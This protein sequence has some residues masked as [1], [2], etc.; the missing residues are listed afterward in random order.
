MPC[1]AGR[2]MYNVRNL[3]DRIPGKALKR[4]CK[5]RELP[6][7]GSVEELRKAL[8]R[9][10]GR[11]V[12]NLLVDL[13]REDL[14]KLFR[15]AVPFEGVDYY[16]P[17][18]GQQ[19]K[20]ALQN[21][22]WQLFAHNQLPQALVPASQLDL[23][24]SSE[25]E[26]D[27]EDEPYEP[28][29]DNHFRRIHDAEGDEEDDPY[30]EGE[31]PPLGL[32]ERV[33]GIMDQQGAMG[34]PGHPLREGLTEGW[35]RPRSL[36]RLLQALD[37]AVPQRLRVSRFQEVI[38]HLEKLGIEAVQADDETLTPFTRDSPSPGIAS[39]VRLR[40]RRVEPPEE[41]PAERSPRAPAAK[42]PTPRPSVPMISPDYPTPPP[43]LVI[44]TT[45]PAARPAPSPHA[46]GSNYELALL[47]LEFLTSVPSIDRQRQRTWPGE[48]LAA[49]TRELSLD[50]RAEKLLRLASSTFVSG[51]HDPM[52]RVVRL[53]SL[54]HAHEWPPLLE[55][56]ARLNAHSQEAVE[57]ITE[58]A[59]EVAALPR[60]TYV[61]THLP[62]VR[63]P[64][65]PPRATPPV[66][67]R[68]VTPPSPV[69]GRPAP[70]P[71]VNK[72]DMG[73]LGDIFDD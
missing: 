31:N 69:K 7:A 2:S 32:S 30:E 71:D 24:A 22:A 20:D 45:P 13:R 9:S 4:L 3:L 21:L 14:S 54:L 29:N 5:L 41:R 27:E 38:D 33:N 64:E 11:Q 40:L 35:S 19:S 8:A 53:A 46:R 12:D 36:S 50:E 63:A 55:D 37:M 28:V 18:R 23:E 17:R 52:S 49:A 68:A 48:F 26:D 44:V 61:A 57:T 43:G 6:L 73:P 15:G 70:T 51:H 65:P 59:I 42:K 1:A 16:L 25:D 72:R 10:Y 56:F 34:G 66:R 39:K 60:V 67:P 58:H 62:P 47:R